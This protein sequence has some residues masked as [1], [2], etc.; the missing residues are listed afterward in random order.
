M[1]LKPA[2]LLAFILAAAALPV[3]AQTLVTVNGSPIP[4]SRADF[5]AKVLVAQ[6]KPDSPQLRE[7]IKQDLI[8]REVMAQEAKRQSVGANPDVKEQLAFQSQLIMIRGLIVDYT[9][10]N[11]ISDA[12]I[13]AEYEKL[14]GQMP[15]EKEYHAR[16]ILLDKEEDAIAII[17]KLKAGE[18]FETLAKQSKDSTA[19]NGGDLDWAPPS[20]YLPEFSA[21]MTKLTKGQITETPVKTK[22]GYHVIKLE[23]VRDPQFPSLEEAKPGIKQH[24][25]DQQLLA[26]QESLKKKAKIK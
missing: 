24:L 2:R 15:G 12:A 19:E 26:F 25:E 21:A 18:K 20:N 7:Q 23:D 11:P 4:K 17:A 9:K 5:M 13:K 10:K 14:K 22:F 3:F 8:N 16:H 1:T 6:G